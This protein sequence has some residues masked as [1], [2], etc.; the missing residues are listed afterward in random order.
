MLFIV[1]QKTR[2]IV[3]RTH[4]M[5]NYLARLKTYFPSLLP[6]VAFCVSIYSLYVSETAQRDVARMEVI[7]TE[8][9]LF[10][11]LAQLQLQYPQMTHL[12][13]VTP[14]TYDLD[15]ERI[16]V[17]LRAA[18][19]TK[20]AGILL[21][22]RALAHYLFTTYEETYYLWRQAITAGDRR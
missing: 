22:E 17:S 6:I 5:F 19:D 14:E 11:D 21:Q 18:D 16:K 2:D 7:K 12:F 9:G 10:H 20:R 13:A 8:Y 4:Q 1:V 15:V 3:R